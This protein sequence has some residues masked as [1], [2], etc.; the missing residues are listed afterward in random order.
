ML[1]LYILWDDWPIYMISGSKEQLQNQL[2]YTLLKPDCHSWSISKMLSGSKEE[3]YAIKFRFK[4]GKNAAETY[5]MLQTAFRS[6]CMNRALFL[7][8]IRDLRKAG[9]LSD[10]ERRG[11]SKVVNTPKLIGQRVG[12]G[13]LCSGFKGIQEEILSEEA[14]TH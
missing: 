7:S 13:L 3:R 9:S 6:S 14:S 1:F 5:G 8:R 2:K 4:P 11:R 10:N 12:L